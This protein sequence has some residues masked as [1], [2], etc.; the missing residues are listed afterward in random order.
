MARIQ[1]TVEVATRNMRRV[2]WSGLTEADS[3]VDY[4]FAEF[5]DR[6]VQVVGDFGT[7]GAATIYTSL[8]EADLAREPSGAGSTWAA[9]TNVDGLGDI[10]INAAVGNKVIQILEGSAFIC[11]EITAGTDVALDIIIEGKKRNS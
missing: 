9:S 5:T 4:D 10:V 3:G 6:S 7:G 8:N 2:R 11:P 1:P